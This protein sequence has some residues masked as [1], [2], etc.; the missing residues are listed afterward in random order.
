MGRAWMS[1]WERPTA[2]LMGTV[3][4]EVP[5]KDTQQS[6]KFWAAALGAWY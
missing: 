2:E 4:S 6:L 3:V 5:L 1:I